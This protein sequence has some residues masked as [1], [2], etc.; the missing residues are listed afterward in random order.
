MQIQFK[1]KVMIQL[2]HF[3]N[4]LALFGISDSIRG[5]IE[6]EDFRLVTVI[7]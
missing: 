7:R 1:G 3:N 4:K 5:F 6:K 2:V